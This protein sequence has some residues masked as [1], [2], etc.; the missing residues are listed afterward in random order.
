MK[1]YII[2]AA[3]FAFGFHLVNAQSLNAVF[4]GRY[5]SGYVS[6]DGGVMEISAFDNSSKKLFTVNGVTG[7]I[8]IINLND[9]ANPAFIASIDLSAYGAGANSV[10]VKNGVLAVAVEDAVKQNNGK[11]VFFNANDNSFLKS[12]V[13]GALPDMLTFTPDGNK[14]LT[15][16]EGEP[17][18]DYSV[19]PEGTVSIIDISNGVANAIE[20]RINFNAFDGQ[21]NTLRAQGIRI[22]GL[23]ANT[24]KDLEP[25]YITISADSKTA[26]IVCQ[27]NNAMATINLVSNSIVSLKSLGTKNHALSGNGLDASDRNPSNPSSVINITNWPVKGMYMPDGIANIRHNNSTFILTANEGD[28]REYTALNEEARINSLTLDTAA[29]ANG[30][31]LKQNS[32]LGR[33]K[34]T[35]VIGDTDNDND[36]DELYCFGA[37]SFSIWDSSMTLVWDSGD[38]FEKY[39]ETT[40]PT[41]FNANHNTENT[42]SNRSDDKGPEPE[43][44]I[45]ATLGDSIYAF[46]GLE[47]ISG[48]MVYNVTNPF[49]PYFVQYI[50]S[51]NFSEV[52]VSTI[53]QVAVTGGDLGPEGLLFI[54][55]NESPNGKPL[56]V[57]SYEVSGTIVIYEINYTA[58]SGIAKEALL[59]NDKLSFY[60]NPASDKLY[61]NKMIS[62]AIYN[63]LGERVSEI[64]NC[65]ITDISKLTNGMYI[66]KTNT[67]TA[68]LFTKE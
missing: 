50:S 65:N 15:A 60:P 31:A 14:V 54:P 53:G 22:F 27:E 32:N 40:N 8:D 44:V 47:R 2:T 18:S 63:I 61:F 36:Y 46:V 10:A 5:T 52:P 25:E 34:V 19:D 16:N 67:G 33:L 28:S 41:Y 38:E 26:W 1:K 55:A 13:V 11:V 51:R 3:L 12:V 49:Q 59:T 7:K 68:T 24:S 37:R 21:E 48:V 45:T 30:S 64:N 39:F 17:A 58:T 66:I 23:S 62:G 29:F 35:N 6:K 9:P 43:S 57:I 20:S 4:K 42:M 56:L